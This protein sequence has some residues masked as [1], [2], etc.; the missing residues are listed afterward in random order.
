[1]GRIDLRTR[2]QRI[3]GAVVLLLIVLTACAI[4]AM[5]LAVAL[6]NEIARWTSNSVAQCAGALLM[7]VIV[8]ATL[9]VWSVL[10]LKA[11][12]KTLGNEP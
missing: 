3:S 1:M 6:S 7:L 8:L 5:F 11:V 4:W 2:R 12:K 9:W 10:L